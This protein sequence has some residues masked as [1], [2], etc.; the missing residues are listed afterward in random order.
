MT[1]SET[2]ECP[3]CYGQGYYYAEVGFCG[4]SN[5]SGRAVMHHC[6]KCNG[7]GEIENPDWEG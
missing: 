4:F 5:P 1:V 2:I 7:E 6:E 3:E